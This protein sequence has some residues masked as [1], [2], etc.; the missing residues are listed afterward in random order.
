MLI[1]LEAKSIMTIDFGIDVKQCVCQAQKAVWL[2][3]S[4]NDTCC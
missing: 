2:R 4:W 3:E 1:L